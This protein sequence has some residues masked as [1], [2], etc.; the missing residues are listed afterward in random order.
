M[1]HSPMHKHGTTQFFIE[2]EGVVPSAMPSP[3]LRA[4]MPRAAAALEATPEPIDT[5]RAF[6]FCRLF[7]DLEKFRPD[8]AGLI[9]LG[10]GAYGSICAWGRGLADSCRVYLL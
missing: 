1:S 5:S 7:P 6:R 9:A 3:R 4:M 2:G 8:D 10:K